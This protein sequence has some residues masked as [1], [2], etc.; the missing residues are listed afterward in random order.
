MSYFR[1][2]SVLVC[3]Q[4]YR[5]RWLVTVGISRLRIWTV[6]DVIQTLVSPV[7]SSSGKVETRLHFNDGILKSEYHC[8][9]LL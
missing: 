9:I 7:V 1:P 6:L 4:M 5:T 8:L 2:S 3:Q